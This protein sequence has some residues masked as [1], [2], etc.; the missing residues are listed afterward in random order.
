MKK[1]KNKGLF[2]V[3]TFMFMAFLFFMLKMYL[4]QK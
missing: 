3:V 4:Q 2:L 1:H